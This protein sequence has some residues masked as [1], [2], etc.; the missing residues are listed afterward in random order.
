VSGELVNGL[1]PMTCIYGELSGSKKTYVQN[2]KKKR[3][4]VTRTHEE[5]GVLR[6]ILSLINIFHLDSKEREEKKENKEKYKKSKNYFLS[7]ID[8]R[9]ETM[10]TTTTTTIDR[11]NKIYQMVRKK[12]D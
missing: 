8:N 9:D 5:K 3:S 7:I 1:L 6:I 4:S 2:K 12:K 11:S 10:T